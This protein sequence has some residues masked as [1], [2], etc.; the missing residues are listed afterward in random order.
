MATS[1]SG[2]EEFDAIVV[3]VGQAAPPLAAGLAGA[4]NHVAVIERKLMGGTCVNVGCT[5]TKTMVASAYAAH[6]ARRA[7]DF[8]VHASSPFTVDLNAVQRRASAVVTRRRE[9]LESWLGGIDGVTMIHG[10]AHFVGQR[11]IEVNG[12][13]LS[14]HKVFL[15][16]GGRV[17]TPSWSGLA[18]VPWLSSTDMLS[19][20]ELPRHLVVV[21]G[22][23]AG[24][25]FAQMYRRFGSEVTIVERGP[26]LARR[27]DPVVSAEIQAIMEA[28]GIVVRKHAE[29]I[30]LA[31]HPEGVIVSVDCQSGDREVVASHVLVA[32]GRRPN[33]DDLGLEA[34]GIKTDDAGYIIVDDWLR[35]SAAGVWALGDC[36]GR[37]AFTHTSYGDADMVLANLLDGENRSLRDRISAY[38]L[39]TDPPLGR[40]G[41]TEAQARAAG[42]RVR[43]GER[44]MDRV[45]RAVERAEADRG[46]MRLVVD[47]DDDRILGG[48]ILGPGGDEAISSIVM[49]LGCGAKATD[50]R[51]LTGIHPTV[52]E[53]LSTL[54]GELG[55]ALE[56]T[57]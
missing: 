45:S 5:P 47:A 31:R 38:A 13:K 21:G 15:D 53:L 4:G 43:V 1:G 22:G 25:E 55:P 6:V 9:G 51:R 49:A 44:R 56:R 50:L 11:E 34:A 24:L 3:G 10:H 14:A 2:V 27:E 37:G 42:H 16:V 19:L 35:T 41:M 29:C 36:N 20:K 39:Y 40:A 48:A 8:G 32:T 28:E 54:A 52:A 30:R 7:A 57:A 33:T 23:Y 18:E 17:S 26:A 46:I 12:R